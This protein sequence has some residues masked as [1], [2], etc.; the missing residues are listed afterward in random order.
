[1]AG[2]ASLTNVRDHYRLGKVKSFLVQK[3]VSLV[4]SND[5]IDFWSGAGMFVGTFP[6]AGLGSAAALSRTS[7]GSFLQQLPLS[8]SM[9]SHIFRV[10]I[11][12]NQAAVN[13][14]E[15]ESWFLLY[16]RLAHATVAVSQSTGSFSPVIDGTARLASGEGAMIIVTATNALGTGT[17]TFTLTYTNQAGTGSRVTGSVTTNASQL[18]GR[19]VYGNSWIP[20]VD[21]QAG[22]TGARTITDWTLSSGTQT[23]NCSVALIKPLAWFSSTTVN[24]PQFKNL[25]LNPFAWPIVHDDAALNL[26]AAFNDSGTQ[27]LQLAVDLGEL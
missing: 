7:D 26:L 16:D 15:Q 24:C 9:R 19:L 20:F 14:E 5:T 4:S 17:N 27:V 13:I 25:I 2:F 21:L 23:G 12:Q 11:L 8:S 1:M 18:A 6:G 22:D 3:D 10:G